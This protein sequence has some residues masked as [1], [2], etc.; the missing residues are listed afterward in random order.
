MRN[1]SLCAYT[2]ISTAIEHFMHLLRLT[3]VSHEAKEEG[4]SDERT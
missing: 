4:P 3:I 2:T 1:L